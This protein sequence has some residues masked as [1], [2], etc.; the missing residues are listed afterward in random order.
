MEN[1]I[2]NRVV[3]LNNSKT[4]ITSR[5]SAANAELRNDSTTSLLDRISGY[6]YNR[7]NSNRESEDSVD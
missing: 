7:F 6:K 4:S 5:E 3:E 2:K 1:D